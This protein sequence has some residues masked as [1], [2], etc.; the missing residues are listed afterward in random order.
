MV[1][2][3]VSEFMRVLSCVDLHAASQMQ[4]WVESPP[5]S[6]GAFPDLTPRDK[7][8]STTWL[9]SCKQ[10]TVGKRASTT[11]TA[12]LGTRYRTR[13][14][15]KNAS[16][17]T[18]CVVSGRCEEEVLSSPLWLQRAREREQFLPVLQ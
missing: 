8:A 6:P 4:H 16:P 14:E 18:R 2:T 11:G 1:K 10:R 15:K 17:G 3:G 9:E 5:A 7:Q 12:K 13:R